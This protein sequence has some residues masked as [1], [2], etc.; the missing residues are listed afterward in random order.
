MPLLLLI[1]TGLLKVG[2]AIGANYTLGVTR[3][4]AERAGRGID[5]RQPHRHEV[6]AG[7]HGLGRNRRRRPGDP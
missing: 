2:Q 4:V 6:A 3:R 1:V 7:L 5:G